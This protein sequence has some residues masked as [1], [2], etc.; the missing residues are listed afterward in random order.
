MCSKAHFRFASG[1][2]VYIETVGEFRAAFKCEPRF[3]DGYQGAESVPWL[4]GDGGSCCCPIDWER[5]V[6]LLG[7][8]PAGD[9]DPFFEI[10]DQV[11]A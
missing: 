3:S 7:F 2:E 5:T 10:Y 8:A 6:G 1:E 4:L 11:R 9:T